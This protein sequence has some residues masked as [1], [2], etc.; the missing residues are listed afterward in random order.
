M[1][2]CKEFQENFCIDFLEGMKI[3]REILKHFNTCGFCK[4]EIK[5]Q[6]KILRI[7]QKL[8]LKDVKFS[9]EPPPFIRKKEKYLFLSLSI[10]FFT[11]FL[12]FHSIINIEFLKAYLYLFKNLPNLYILKS[13]PFLYFFGITSFSISLLIYLYM[14]KILKRI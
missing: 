11:I 6:E 14:K 1:E 7:F 8:E 4:G 3:P 2:K 5:K 10:F 9:F 12:L 13:N